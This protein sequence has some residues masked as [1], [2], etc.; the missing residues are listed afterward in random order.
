[1]LA[2]L[3]LTTGAVWGSPR[4]LGL[5]I[6][7]GV[8]S[9]VVPYVLDQ[10]VLRRVGRARFALLLALLPATAVIVGLVVLRQVPSLPEVVGIGL[11][12]AAIALTGRSVP[13]VT[14]V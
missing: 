2:P 12:V 9:S 1:V 4:L 11:V 6:G 7:V 10:V 14:P 13:A 5:G 3:G 8:L